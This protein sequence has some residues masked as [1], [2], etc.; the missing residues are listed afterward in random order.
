MG[1]TVRRS[2]LHKQGR[3]TGSWLGHGP[4]PC[5]IVRAYYEHEGILSAYW[6]SQRPGVMLL[7]D[8][9]V[10]VKLWGQ[11]SPTVA[12]EG[13]GGEFSDPGKSDGEGW[14]VHRP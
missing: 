10:A 1:F 4:Q 3:G 8:Q 6:L 2:G 13:Q 7:E 12:P 14:P 5:P 11:D 9:E